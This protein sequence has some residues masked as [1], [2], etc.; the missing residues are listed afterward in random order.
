MTRARQFGS[1][2]ELPS[3]TPAHRRYQA[4]YR[5]PAGVRRAAPTIFTTKRDAG[6]WLD[7]QH[8]AIIDG[9]WK[10]PELGTETFRAYAETWLAERELKPRTRDHY[11]KILDRYLLPRFGSV[12]LSAITSPAV[13]AWH[14]KLS[15]E[16]GPT[17]RA[18]CYGLLR[19][20]LGT[21][22]NDGAL[23]GNPC[24][25]RGAGSTKRVVRIE[26]ATL[27]ALAAIVAKMPARLQMMTLLAAWCALRFGEL[28]ELRR[29]DVDL[30]RAV[31]DIRRGVV[32]LKGGRL[33]GTPKSD[34]GTRTVSIPPHLIEPL[35]EH[36]A[37]HAQ[38]GADGL[39]FPSVNGK[40]LATRTLYDS[41]YPAR[42]AAGRPDLRFHDL[43]HTGAVLAAA[44][45]A[46]L[47]D[48]MHRLG[49][50][51][52][53]AAMRYQHASEQRDQDIAARL[54][55]F[56]GSNVVPLRSRRTAN[57]S[58]STRAGASRARGGS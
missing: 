44:T 27:P 19:T 1:I 21:A 20:I 31:L 4:R 57:T 12:A 7:K 33:V 14:A 47:A 8:A 22:V 11:R 26:P 51:T 36:L 3:S 34:A 52:P 58:G 16:T 37:E 43:R 17:M 32:G 55:E 46:T 35:R 40:H 23:N 42:E 53:A 15:T 56:A 45:G 24:A 28:A 29:Q 38:R 54:S 25:I 48:L 49:H 9:K 13:R 6:G 5:D 41:Y 30:D 50:S 39:L 2:R 18:H 10:A